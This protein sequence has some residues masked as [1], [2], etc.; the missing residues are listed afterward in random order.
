VHR[1]SGFEVNTVDAITVLKGYMYLTRRHIC[2]FAHMPDREVGHIA[3]S[4]SKAGRPADSPLHRTS[5]SKQALC[6]RGHGQS[7]TPSTGLF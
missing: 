5:L 6:T 3:P 2:F 1:S 4:L 7:S